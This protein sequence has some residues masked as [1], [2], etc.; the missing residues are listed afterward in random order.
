MPSHQHLPSGLHRVACGAV[1][2]VGTATLASDLLVR[3]Q[4]DSW[5]HAVSVVLLWLSVPIGIVF[6]SIASHGPTVQT[7]A[8]L[9]Q[10]ASR[11]GHYTS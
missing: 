8:Q 7:C 4:T 6:A 5:L 9:I 10:P 1:A 2:I 11:K 3:S